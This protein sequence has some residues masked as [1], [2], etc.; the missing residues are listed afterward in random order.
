MTGALVAIFLIFMVDAAVFPALP[1]ILIVLFYFLYPR[2]GIDA[3]AWALPLL[4]VGVAGDLAGNFALYW[5]VRNALQRRNRMPE[6]I[7]R[8]M[9]R[10][11]SFLL[12]RDERII[13]LNRIAPIVPLTGAFIAVCHWNLRRA[14]LY[15]AVGGAAK[16]AALL[17]IAGWLGVTFSSESAQVGTLIVILVLV[18]ASAIAGRLRRRSAKGAMP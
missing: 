9:R 3:V 6:I 13:L 16:Y 17:A 8:A 12:V 2:F 4:A 7:E 15:V 14:L 11:T 5:F 18:A 10:W 1:E